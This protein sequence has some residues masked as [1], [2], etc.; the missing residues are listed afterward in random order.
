MCVYLYVVYLVCPF[1]L[2]MLTL[3]LLITWIDHEGRS[4]AEK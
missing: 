4:E 3:T 2:C 1:S